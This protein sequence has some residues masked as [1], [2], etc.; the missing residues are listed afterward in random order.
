MRGYQI[1]VVKVA[2]LRGYTLK[3]GDSMA[4]D[5]IGYGATVPDALVEEMRRKG[6]EVVDVVPSIEEANPTLAKLE[7]VYEGY[8]HLLSLLSRETLDYVFIFHI[9]HHF[10]SEI[11]RTLCDLKSRTKI[12]GY[13]H[14][15]HWNPTDV[16]R[17]INYPNMEL[18]DLSNLQSLDIIYQVSE[19]A[20]KVMDDEIGKFNP[21]TA[22]KLMEKY[23]VVG[24]PVNTKLIDK[25]KTEEK[26]DRLTIVFNH[27]LISSKNPIMF[28][29]VMNRLLKRYD[30]QV[31]F[32]RSICDD[33]QISSTLKRLQQDHPKSVSFIERPGPSPY[34]P[35]LWKSHVQVSTATHETFGV[36][37][38]E[39]MYTENC[40][41][42]PDHCSYPE[43]TGYYRDCLY[44]YSEEGL[45]QKLV[46]V[47]EDEPYRRRIGRDL[48]ERSKRYQPEEVVAKIVDAMEHPPK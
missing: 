29:K 38:V 6:V 44:P 10:P 28:A 46:K 4:T 34:Y 24:L 23:R 11:R 25:F 19:Y 1:A 8:R 31:I 18:V 37:T 26:F 32:T 47:I 27:N 14:G 22:E 45:Y 20:V 3:R 42:L 33:E 36:A 40:C 9:F 17:F 41:I 48:R 5:M 35:T 43:I 2:F 7:W 12:C 21:K 15:S 39:A 30:L 13:T 16:F